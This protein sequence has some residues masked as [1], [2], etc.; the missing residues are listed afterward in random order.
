MNPVGRLVIN[1]II[2]WS[3][4]REGEWLVVGCAE[5]D[6]N[7]PLFSLGFSDP[8]RPLMCWGSA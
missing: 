2:S 7:S 8:S 3:V 4:C 5:G 6:S 1:R